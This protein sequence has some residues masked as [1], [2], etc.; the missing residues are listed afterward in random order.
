[1]SRKPTGHF[2]SPH[3]NEH[4]ALHPGKSWSTSQVTASSHGALLHYKLVWSFLLCQ[5]VIEFL[6][7]GLQISRC[8]G[9]SCQ[10]FEM[11]EQAH[12]GPERHCNQPP[13]MLLYVPSQKVTTGLLPAQRRGLQS[14]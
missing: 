5:I 6:L 11:M 1:M 13:L 12:P 14:I 7:F 4:S 3:G 10:V 9:C 2:P 8:A